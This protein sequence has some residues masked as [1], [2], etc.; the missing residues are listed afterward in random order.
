MFA[1]KITYSTG[2]SLKLKHFVLSTHSFKVFST[3]W[4]LST[5]D[6]F[7]IFSTAWPFWAIL[8][9]LTLLSYF[10]LLD[11]FEIFSAAWPFWAILD[12]LTFLLTHWTTKLSLSS[13]VLQII[14]C[15]RITYCANPKGHCII[16]T[17]CTTIT[18][19]LALITR[20]TCSLKINN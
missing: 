13:Y 9:Y 19:C 15:R 10:Q 2:I 12:Y 3:T 17:R 1:T 14:T 4:L 16:W 5:I 11:P 6:P 20:W 18:I 8:H 7:E